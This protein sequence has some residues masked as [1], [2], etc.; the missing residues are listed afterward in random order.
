MENYRHMLKLLFTGLMIY[1][2]YKVFI[3]PNRLGGGEENKKAPLIKNDPASGA[4]DDD[5]EYT[6]YEEIE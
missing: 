1:L 4:E 5:G 2:L 6:D 3:S